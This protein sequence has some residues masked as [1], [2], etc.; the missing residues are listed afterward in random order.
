MA[1]AQM[2]TD[3]VALVNG[4]RNFDRIADEIKS[5][6]ARVQKTANEL[7]GGWQGTAAKAAHNALE[8]F[9]E[10]A[11]AHVRQLNEITTNLQAAASHYAQTDDERAG[12]IAAAMGSAMNRRANGRGQG[13]AG[14]P[15]TRLHP[16]TATNANGQHGGVVSGVWKH[17]NG[18]SNPVQFVDFKQDGGTQPVPQPSPS[19]GQPQ[20][21]PFPVPPQVAAAAP[22][23]VPPPAPA[24]S[25]P[26]PSGPTRP[27][28]GQCVEDHVQENIGKEMVKDGFKSAITGA[29][30][31]GVAG[32]VGGAAVTPEA[33]GAGAIPGAIGG[34][35]LGFVGGFGKGLLEAPIKA[36][37]EGAWDCAK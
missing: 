7:D 22:Q 23:R 16:A 26:A 5:V 27:S 9:N 24:R 10:A 33:A 32:G 8:R 6:I 34:V 19:Q 20:I 15:D 13:N 29:I 21:G 36:A 18:A 37:G 28:F 1:P 2:T 31:G 25:A 4:A 11:D 12:A 17:S 3:P 30:K 14:S 35:V